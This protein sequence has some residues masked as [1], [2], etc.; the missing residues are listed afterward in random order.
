MSEKFVFFW[1]GPFSQWYPSKFKYPGWSGPSESF[2]CAEQFMMAYKAEFFQDK[3]TR[4]KIMRSDSPREQK[5]LGRQV[6]NFDAEKWDEV[7]RYIVYLGNYFKFIENDSLRDILLQTE[8][9]TLVEAS[10]YDKIWGIGLG[11]DD[12][13]RLDRNEWQGTNWLGE[14]LMRVRDDIRDKVNVFNVGIKMGK[15]TPWALKDTR[16][17][18]EWSK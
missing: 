10:P 12:P 5:K 6:K 7:S 18:I 15:F 11:E 14:V 17:D 9:M 16:K 2:N 4:E 13:K 8:G 3:E 1:N